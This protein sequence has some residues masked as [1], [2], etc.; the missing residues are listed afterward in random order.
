MSRFMQVIGTLFAVGLVAAHPGLS[1]AQEV[2][3]P[4]LKYVMSYQANLDPPQVVAKDRL[5]WNVTGGWVKAAT[6]ETGTFLNPCG[7]W[8]YLLPGGNMKLDV[9]CTVKMDDGALI[10]IEYLGL[11]K[12]S[13]K[14]AEKF[15]E[16]LL[17]AGDDAYFMTNPLMRTTSAKYGWVNDA[18]FLE[19]FAALQPPAAG[20]RAI[21]R[22]HGHALARIPP[23]GGHPRRPRF[24]L[25]PGGCG[26]GLGPARPMGGSPPPFAV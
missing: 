11:I 19:K 3:P 26:S 21:R 7:D 4:K 9:R 16:G 6:G 17:L 10:Y 24:P 5:V 18:I 23:P 22:L 14:G 25:T 12:L 2:S 1:S 13:A 20:F 8:M 15:Q